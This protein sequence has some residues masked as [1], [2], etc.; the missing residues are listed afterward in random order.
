M[1]VDGLNLR[2]HTP[3]ATAFPLPMYVG[4]GFIQCLAMIPGVSALGRTIV[5]AMLLGAD[6]RSRPSSR[7]FSHAHHGGRLR[8]TIS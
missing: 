7:S 3:P 6:K 4:I 2:R 5:G 1:V 8:R